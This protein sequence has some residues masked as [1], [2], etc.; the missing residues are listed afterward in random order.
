MDARE[1]AILTGSVPPEAKNIHA[2]INN[3]QGWK[4]SSTCPAMPVPAVSVGRA[5]DA[6]RRGM[7]NLEAPVRPSPGGRGLQRGVYRPAR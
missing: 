5:P 7:W 2:M 6:G 4:P 1:S 3:D